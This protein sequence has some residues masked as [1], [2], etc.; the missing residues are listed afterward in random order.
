[1][2]RAYQVRACLERLHSAQGD[3]YAGG[4]AAPLRA[5][6]CRDV[7]WH[8]PGGSDIAGTYLGIEEVIRYFAR[9]RELASRTFRMHPAELLSGPGEHAAMITHGEVRI[10]GAV[11]RWSTVGLYR[12]RGD[13]VA[14]CRLLPFDQAE[15]DRIWTRSGSDG[16]TS[17][18][19]NPAVYDR[20]GA[21]Y[22]RHR[23][24]D[25]RI[26][27]AV[28][29]ALERART[30]VNVGAGAGSYEPADRC[31]IAVEPSAAMLAQRAERS[32]P[33]LLAS[34]AALPLADDSVDAAMAILTLHHWPD[35]RAGLV[36][37]RRVAR[38]RVV[39]LT[40]D[41]EVGGF[42][43]TQDYLGWLAD[44]DAQRFPTM[45]EVLA[46]LPGAGVSPVPVPRDCA[47]G[48]LAAYFARPER[49]LDEEVRA[50]M[51]FF[52]LAPDPQ[53]VE[54]SLRSLEEDLQSG[55]WDARYGSL[56]RAASID[57]GYRLVVAP[58]S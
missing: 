4:D 28:H 22:A 34:V 31:V 21:G 13:R 5:V 7:A 46:E 2:T 9:R 47:D 17:G 3:F 50:A 38:E 36:E 29:A 6:L 14:E 10:D 58:A 40:W 33:A 54:A 1:M 16:P 12:L 53:R 20:I 48:F 35:W 23:R 32:A 25:P 49:Y 56:R 15:F 26:A 27:A 44:W 57:A 45:E 43:L 41:T 51:S 18:K 8:V 55:A 39:L 37:M 52:A 24:P 42:W 30:V 11:R 19:D